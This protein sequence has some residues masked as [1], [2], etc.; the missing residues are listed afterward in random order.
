MEPA[1]WVDGRERD[2]DEDND[3]SEKER[4]FAR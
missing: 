1:Q 3:E 2:V 4:L